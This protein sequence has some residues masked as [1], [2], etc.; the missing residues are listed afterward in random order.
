MIFTDEDFRAA[1]AGYFSGLDGTSDDGWAELTD[2]A[3]L[4]DA[5]VAKYGL[6]GYQ[7]EAPL[8]WSD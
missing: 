5:E 8:P 7:W 6:R 1:L 3:V 4:E 2:Q